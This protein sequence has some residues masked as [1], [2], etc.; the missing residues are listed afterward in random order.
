MGSR[1]FLRGLRALIEAIRLGQRLSDQPVV[2]SGHY[3]IAELL[4]LA[5]H[6]Q[7]GQRLLQRAEHLAATWPYW[8]ND[9]YRQRKSTAIRALFR[10]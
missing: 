3:S 1:D 8:L 4:Y 7:L 10:R 9:P 2:I 5:G 6:K